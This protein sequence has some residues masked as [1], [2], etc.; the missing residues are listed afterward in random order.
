MLNDVE[1]LETLFVRLL[2]PKETIHIEGLPANVV[3]IRSSEQWI[4]CRLP[5]D[6]EVNINRKQIPV[7]PNFAITYYVSQ[8]NTRLFNVIDPKYLETYQ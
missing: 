4:T 5:N 3:P 1:I 2:S 8:G 7:I 6:S